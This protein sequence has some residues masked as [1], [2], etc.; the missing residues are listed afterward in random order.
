MQEIL[1]VMKQQMAQMSLLHTENTRL[2]EAAD[3]AAIAAPSTPAPTTNASDGTVTSTPYRSKRPDRP[4]INA[5]LDDREWALFE[6][7]WV[8]Y[9]TMINVTDVAAIRMELR[10]A[11]S[12]DVNRLLFEFV[13]SEILDA[14]TEKELL[15]HIKS[16]AVKSVHKE[17]HRM[18]FNTMCQ[19][20]GQSITNFVAK[21]KAKAFLCQFNVVCTGHDPHLHISYSEEMVSQR[22]I[23]GL[24][25][26]EH[27]RRILAEAPD[28]PTLAE[29]IARLQVL[30]TTEESVSLLHNKPPPPPS[31]A[32]AARSAYKKKKNK[33][34]REETTPGPKCRFC[35]RTSH[36]GGQSVNDRATCP[37]RD[38]ECHKCHT[39]GHLAP[40]CEKTNASANAATGNVDGA[41][42]E[43]MLDQIPSEASFS[44][45]FGASSPDSSV[46]ESPVQE[47]STQDFRSGRQKN[48]RV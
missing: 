30:E 5:A 33:A 35:G 23:A 19:D 14:C 27:Q 17:V 20:H 6:D 11:C 36:P 42:E 32:S 21:L 15:A 41:V 45:A 38:K 9:K 28:L 40:V 44:F 48:A 13:G 18:A 37:A 34:T 26:Q 3:A 16:V 29:K 46:Q 43:E 31:Q 24:R 47:S 25:N 12:D 39:M 8:R 1:E 7:T 4:V 10:A 22:L 2:R